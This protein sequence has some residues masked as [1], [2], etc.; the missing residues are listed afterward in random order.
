M[1]P[2]GL[3]IVG[4]I[5]RPH[6]V[7]GAVFVDLITDLTERVAPGARLWCRDRLLEITSSRPAGARWVVTFDGIDD[8][9]TAATL[10]S[11]EIFAEPVDVPGALWVH[12]MIGSEVVETD[13]TVR[14]VCRAVIDN[15][16]ADLIELDSGALV[17]VT[18]VIDIA[19]GRIMVE[20][21]DGLFEL[22]EPDITHEAE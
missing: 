5:G 22:T 6:G 3:L 2:E 9:D 13:G 8:R 17:P 19:P 21:P 4:R 7:R 12:E 15:P 11:V 18:F 14:G 1:R 20:V 10:T 16:A